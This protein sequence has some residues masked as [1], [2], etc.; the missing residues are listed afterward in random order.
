MTVRFFGGWDYRPDDLKNRSFAWT[1]YQ[2]GV[3]MGGDLAKASADKAPTFLVAA[4]RDPMFGNLERIQIIKGPAGKDGERHEHVCRVERGGR[5]APRSHEIDRPDGLGRSW[6]P[7]GRGHAAGPPSN[8]P[9]QR[10][11]SAAQAVPRLEALGA[12]RVSST[13]PFDSCD[14]EATGLLKRHPP[15]RSYRAP[16]FVLAVTGLCAALLP[17]HAGAYSGALT[18]TP[19]VRAAPGTVGLGFGYRLGDSP[20]RDID[21]LSSVENDFGGDLVPL[22]LYEGK[23]LFAHG[24]SA[25]LHL[26]RGSAFSLDAVARYRFDRL[27]TDASPYYAGMADREQTVDGG[28]SVTLEQPWGS[29][30]AT[31]VTDLLSRHDGEAYDLTYRYTFGIGRLTLSPFAGYVHQSGKLNDYYYGVTPAESRPDR[32]AYE[33]GGDGFWQAG[34]NTSYRLTRGWDLYANVAFEQVPDAV[35]ASPLVDEEN[36][37]SAFIGASYSFGNLE[38]HRLVSPARKGEWSWRVNAGY[39]VEEDFHKVHRGLVRR[40]ADVHTY[41]AGLTLGR[42]LQDG[43]KVDFWGR[44]SLNRRLENGLQDDFFEYVAYVMAMGSGFSPWTDRELFRYGF[45]FGFSYAGRVPMVEQ[46]KQDDRGE[47]TSHLLSY[48]EAQVDFPLRNIFGEGAR[49][50]CYIGL[51]LVHRSGLFATSDIFGNISGGSNVLTGHLECKY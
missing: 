40:S 27:E 33:A 13:L 38:D 51:T 22:Y 19:I 15:A 43:D 16:E 42:L 6:L 5:A 34:L 7:P 32:P 23:H 45:G 24:T 4:M 3:P 12:A 25:G 37:L 14:D 47:E 1:G 2:K 18:E 31:A 36:L 9:A 50:N 46:V 39:T 48:L 17:P 28:F 30:T 8:S 21:D 49:D 26:F 44:V 10:D 35:R 11:R 29:L 20:Y 41:L